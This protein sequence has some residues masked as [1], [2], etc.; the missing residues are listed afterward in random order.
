MG[1]GLA[2]D[3][4]GAALAPPRCAVCGARSTAAEPL[5]G[6]C[7]RRLLAAPSGSAHLAGIGRV[8]WAAPYEGAARELVTAL[9]FGA[10][11]GLA[12]VAAGRI[13]AAL[14]GGP[15]D[16]TIV[17]VPA[18]SARRRRRGYDPAELIA[19]RLARRLGLAVSPALGRV[20]GARQVGRRRS[21]RVRSPP[22][23]R[24]MGAVPAAALLVDDVLTTGATL[25]ACAAA[26]AGSGCSEVRAAV[27]A[28][29]LGHRC[30]PA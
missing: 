17:P 5:C 18:A 11:L 24:A 28:R 21:E 12:E 3:L 10:R 14:A 20:D 26:L 29:A 9:K 25:R 22:S 19:N 30:T 4:L 16:L 1:L 8:V 7:D 2:I 15:S 6:R 13:A 27:F 23:V